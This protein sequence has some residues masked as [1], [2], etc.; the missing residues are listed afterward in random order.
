MKFLG[1]FLSRIKVH[2][3]GFFIF[4]SLL[5]ATAQ[6]DQNKKGVVYV[7]SLISKI[8]AAIRAD[9]FLGATRNTNTLLKVGR[10]QKDTYAL[11]NAYNLRGI[12]F[13]ATQ[14]LDSSEQSLRKSLVLFEQLKDK[15][16]TQTVKSNLAILTKKKYA[17]RDSIAKMHKLALQMK[18]DHNYVY[19]FLQSEYIQSLFEFGDMNGLYQA[20][21]EWLLEYENFNFSKLAT[22][23]KRNI[24]LNLKPFVLANKGYALIENQEFDEGYKFLLQ[25]EKGFVRK[26]LDYQ[27]NK[28]LSDYYFYRAK[29]FMEYKKHKDSLNFFLN[30]FHE[31]NT[32]AYRNFKIEYKESLTKLEDEKRKSELLSLQN[33]KNKAIAGQ[34]NWIAVL[35]VSAFFVT[36]ILIVIIYRNNVYRKHIQVVLERKNSELLSIDKDRNHFF[37]IVAHEL[38]TPI[39]SVKGLVELICEE[40]RIKDE[41]I[42]SHI[43]SLATLSNH[44]S[45][46]VDNILQYAKFNLGETKL[47]GDKL[48]LRTFLQEFIEPYTVHNHVFLEVDE[49]VCDYLIFDRIKISQI[50]INLIRNAIKFSEN[51][52]IW[53]TVKNVTQ[54]EDTNTIRFAVRDE[55]RGIPKDKIASVFNA[56]TKSNSRIEYDEGTGLGLFVVKNIVEL[57]NSEIKV[58]SEEGK[59]TEFSF[60]LKLKKYKKIKEKES[61][62]KLSLAG[63]KILVVDDNKINLMIT[64]K[65]IENANGLCKVTNNG[66]DAIDLVKEGNFD[67]VLM[68]IHM[69]GIDG[70]EASR[71]I[72]VFNKD[73]PIIALTAVDFESNHQSISDSGINAIVSKPFSVTNL[74]E[75]IHT[76][77]ASDVLVS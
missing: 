75:K 10:K 39:Y 5:N 76:L 41:K 26:K 58:Y 61:A 24:K 28:Q 9:D 25:A 21:N 23:Y 52:K 60:V 66:Y 15:Q 63:F 38:R 3:G 13:G 45:L 55:G 34:Y 68:D 65:Y 67:V 19:F 33:E 59:G 53:I 73:I 20:T 47:E 6:E 43:N 49:D 12:V 32:L 30:K 56:F 74:T 27:V 51:G 4:F 14:K 11:A 31:K 18:R 57:Y 35:A 2:V 48:E 42:C 44:L 77:K 70:M 22:E 16:K 64:K 72:R 50:F 46:F 37:S 8:Y 17:S 29:Y 54:D 1:M 36:L 7:D 40:V 69:P 71:R 62:E